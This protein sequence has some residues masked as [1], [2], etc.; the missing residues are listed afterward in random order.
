MVY[1]REK[2]RR[3]NT[4]WRKAHP[5]RVRK[6]ARVW[7]KAHPERAR[8]RAKAWY[9]AH[10]EQ[11]KNSR[12]VIR[13]TELLIIAQRWGDEFPRC[14]ADATPSLIDVPCRGKL[15]VD[16][17]N[18]GGRE[19]LTWSRLMGVCNGTRKLDDLRVLCELHQAAYAIH[20]GDS[21]GG[22]DPDEWQDEP[23]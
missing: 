15:Q 16:H 13:E 6:I 17:L 8:E 20:R 7:Y 3:A 14:R 23:L 9:K 19:E 10:P 1:D 12:R 11:I 21:V 4:K 5:E 22:S 18:G 2:A